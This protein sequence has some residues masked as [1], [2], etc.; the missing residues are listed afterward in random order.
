ML[1]RHLQ[2]LRVLVI[3]MAFCLTL[4]A[5]AAQDDD[6]EAHDVI[7]QAFAQLADADGYT[8]VL[9]MD[10]TNRIIDEAGESFGT[11]QLYKIDGAASGPDYSDTVTLTTTPLENEAD[12]QATTL[13][14]VQLGDEFYVLLDALLADQLGIAPGWWLLDDLLD[15]VGVDSV[16]AYSAAQLTNIPN[17]AAIAF[18][19]DLIR[20]VTETEPGEIDGVAVRVFDVEM[21]AVEMVM[22]QMEVT[23]VDQLA[24][25]FENAALLLQ[26]EFSITYRLWI[27]AD[28]GRLYRG[29]SEARTYLP[30]VDFGGANDPD[31]DIENTGSVTFEIANYGAPVEIE[32]PT[33]RN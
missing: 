7:A 28:D 26:S 6:A 31:Y 33:P 9:T 3:V 5:V 1:N 25:Y 13:K 4:A 10:S 20:N 32:A 24:L 2:H 14:R 11:R 8:Y 27:G 16:R 21:K 12:E 30:F 22:A 18:D 15:A 17:P 19:I 29:A 23:A